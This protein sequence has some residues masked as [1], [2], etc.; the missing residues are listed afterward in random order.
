MKGIK[1]KKD[2]ELDTI[3]SSILDN[4]GVHQT[5]Y[6]Q[7]TNRALCIQ[8]TTKC[9]SFPHLPL[10]KEKMSVN[11]VIYIMVNLSS[12]Q[13]NNFIFQDRKLYPQA[14]MHQINPHRSKKVRQEGLQKVHYEFLWKILCEKTLKAIR[15]G[16][17]K[18]NSRK[19]IMSGHVHE[20]I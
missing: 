3:V 2:E 6:D 12:N 1:R 17:N 19:E 4:Q 15:G 18:K 10:S 13:V 8:T 11:I 16:K 9:P 5:L 14:T 7:Q 20:C